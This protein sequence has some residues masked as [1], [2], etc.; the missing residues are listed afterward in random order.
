[1]D[2]DNITRR[3]V[4]LFFAPWVGAIM[5]IALTLGALLI[6]FGFGLDDKMPSLAHLR[7]PGVLSGVVGGVAAIGYWMLNRDR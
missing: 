2:L 3:D 6:V 4:K 7:W 5:I 1:M